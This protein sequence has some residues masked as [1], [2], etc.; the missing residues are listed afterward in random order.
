VI[1]PTVN[2]DHVTSYAEAFQAVVRHLLVTDPRL[3]AAP[4]KWES[5]R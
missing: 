1:I 2:P 5:T 3:K 4:T